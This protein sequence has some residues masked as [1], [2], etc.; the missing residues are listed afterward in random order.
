MPLIKAT[1]SNRRLTDI[2]LSNGWVKL[3]LNPLDMFSNVYCV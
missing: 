3:V 1:L 2:R